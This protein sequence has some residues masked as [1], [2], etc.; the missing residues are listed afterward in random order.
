MGL[1]LLSSICQARRAQMRF[2]R[3][4]ALEAVHASKID[5]KKQHRWVSGVKCILSCPLWLQTYVSIVNK[6]MVIYWYRNSLIT[7]DVLLIFP[8]LFDRWKYDILCDLCSHGALDDLIKIH[9]LFELSNK[10]VRYDN[11]DVFRL[12]CECGHLDVAKWL[13]TTFHLTVDD[14]R[15]HDNYVYRHARENGHHNVCDWLVTTFGDSVKA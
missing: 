12:A 4:N 13:Y 7:Y 6:F 14:V 2:L 1:E 15:S 3:A 8:Q 5:A 9:D 10:D 11:N